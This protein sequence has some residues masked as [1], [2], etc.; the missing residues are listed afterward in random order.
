[1]SA[2][3]SDKAGR[4]YWESIWATR[5]AQKPFDPATDTGVSFWTGQ[6]F[7]AFFSEIFAGRD[8]QGLKLIEVGC[9]GST[10]LPYFAREFG[11]AVAGLDYSELGCEQERAILD[12]AGVEGEVVC[13]DLFDPPDHLKG[14]FDVVVSFGVVEHFHETAMAVRAIVTLAKP[15]GTV[16]SFIPN[17]SGAV[18]LAT[19][20]L[21]PAVYRVHVPLTARALAA[22]H[23]AAGTTVGRSGYFMSTGFAV[24][25]LHGLV[26]GT[27]FYTARRAVHR[28]L[29]G[30]SKATWILESTTRPLPPT[31]AFAPYAYCVAEVPTGETGKR[32]A[33]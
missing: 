9:A 13:A 32:R 2:R 29:R 14:T 30:V 4:A 1:M 25:N 5:P 19:L 31:R 27:R 7:H 18:G 16:V 15:G 26:P 22:A 11:F 20:I 12:A 33:E 17:L 28:L 10:W 6:R 24:A 23:Q 8:G 3:Q 21:N